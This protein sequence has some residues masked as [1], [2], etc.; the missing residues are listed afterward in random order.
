M[1]AAALDAL[2]EMVIVGDP[3]GRILYWNEAA[4]RLSGWRADEVVGSDALEILLTEEDRP[5]GTAIVTMLRRGS[6]WSGEIAI[7]TR[8]G[9]LLPA[10]ATATPMTTGSGSLEGLVAVIRD[11]SG[12]REAESALAASEERLDLLRRA[13]QSVIWEL[14]TESRRVQWSDGLG[15]AFG[16]APEDVEPT[17]DWWWDRIH[18]EDRPRLEQ[19]FEAFLSDDHHFWTEEYRFQ[20]ADGSYAS[21]FHRA[22][23]PGRSRGR[24]G[25]IAGAMVDLTER[26]QLQDE[27]R[28]LAQASMILDL[29]LDYE[30][31]L[32]SLARLM[33]DAMADF[34][35]IHLTPQPER[36]PFTTAVHRDPTRQPVLDELADRLRPAHPARSTIGRVLQTGEPRLLRNLA[37]QLRDEPESALREL[38][39]RLGSTSALVLPVS[40]R[41]ETFGF[42]VL[43]SNDRRSPYGDPDLRIAEELARRIGTAVDHARL[44]ESEQLARQAK[45]DFLAIMSHELRTPLT[46][47]LGY[48]DL[49]ADEISGPLNPRQQEQVQRIRAGSDRLYRLMESILAYVRLESGHD[50]PRREWVRFRSI[51]E[52]VEEVVGPRA[53]EEGVDFQIDVD[54]T[55]PSHLITDPDRVLQILLALL[56]NALKFDR[57]GEVRLRVTGRDDHLELDV[58]DT[59]AGI[60][61]EHQPHVFNAFWQVE[62]PATRRAGGA[63]LGLS[64]ARRMARLLGGDVGIAESSPGGTTF[65][66]RL[67]VNLRP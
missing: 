55:V 28:L 38:V 49:L 51:L 34:C 41:S 60:P 43:G 16:Y 42:V 23:A 13:A 61:P 46:A 50:R 54:D 35:L 31:T 53:A 66:F 37:K 62:Q 40:A 17:L 25:P 57:R 15:D 14:D 11:I 52:R 65:R 48:A 21:V 24:K 5:K 6:S 64:L 29:S 47:V 44:F 33:A 9:E 36:G 30:A 8:S 2:G 59:G 32:P 10:I 56:T 19:S 12:Q 18:P 27:R 22:Y 58:S 67:P 39:T 63:G 20:R 3:E 7:R 45:T 4:V 1:R 26:R